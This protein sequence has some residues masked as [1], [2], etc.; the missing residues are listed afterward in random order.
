MITTVQVDVIGVDASEKGESF[1]R[2]SFPHIRFESL[3]VKERS[4]TRTELAEIYGVTVP[5]ITKDIQAL[6][7]WRDSENKPNYLK[8]EKKSSLNFD[9]GYFVYL[10][11]VWLDQQRFANETKKP[12]KSVF[13]RDVLN[14]WLVDDDGVASL[15]R[16]DAFTLL[17]QKALQSQGKN[18]TARQ[19][20]E[21]LLEDYL[22][23][24]KGSGA[25][26]KSSQD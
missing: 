7:K 9:Q 21:R 10:L 11:R 14:H 2:R 18:I 1:I 12:L 3:S 8:Y 6:M 5:M 25:I 19:D 24:K 26:L 20:Y 22:T 13:V 4:W 17:I 15:P 23:R 16:L